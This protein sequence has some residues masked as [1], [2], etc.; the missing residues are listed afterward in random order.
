MTPSTA[1]RMPR[2]P[3]ERIRR[4]THTAGGSRS[5]IVVWSTTSMQPPQVRPLTSRYDPAQVHGSVGSLS[6]KSVRARGDSQSWPKSS[7]SPG[8]TM[9]SSPPVNSAA[10]SDGRWTSSTCGPGP[11]YTCV[12]PL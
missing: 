2:S 4:C 7:D 5:A 12:D 11:R 1:L 3:R 9:F 8:S 10:L 6:P